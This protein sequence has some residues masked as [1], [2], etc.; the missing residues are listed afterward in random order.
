[1][2]ALGAAPRPPLA[3]AAAGGLALGLSFN[4]LA[5]VVGSVAAAV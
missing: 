5:A 2:A 3:R 1:M 4:P